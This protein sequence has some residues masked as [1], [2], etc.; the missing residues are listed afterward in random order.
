MEPSRLYFRRRLAVPRPLELY[1]YRR[2]R[3]RSP[4]RGAARDSRPHRRLEDLKIDSYGSVTAL[5]V[6]A[7][8]CYS[9]HASQRFEALVSSAG[10]R[11]PR[12]PPATCAG[13]EGNDRQRLQIGRVA[14]RER[15]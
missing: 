11:V 4:P 7:R 5:S 12:T 15:V 2:Y 10:D 1:A 14:I 13:C 8:Q 9:P 3:R 6:A